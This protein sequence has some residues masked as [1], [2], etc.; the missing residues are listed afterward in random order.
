M[1]RFKYNPG[2]ISKNNCQLISRDYK[3]NNNVWI[4]TFKCLD[5]GTIFQNRLKKVFN[6]NIKIVFVIVIK[7]IYQVKKKVFIKFYLKHQESQKIEIFIGIVYVKN[8]A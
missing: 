5:C 1:P 4:G 8:V 2:D 7:I 6:E 3:D